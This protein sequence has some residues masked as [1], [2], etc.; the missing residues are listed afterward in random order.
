MVNTHIRKLVAAGKVL[1]C[2][3]QSWLRHIQIG[4]NCE[5]ALQRTVEAISSCEKEL[6]ALAICE[7]SQ[8]AVFRQA[9]G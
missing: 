5:E 8:T 1:I 9:F 6:A 3:T 2:D 4:R 7:Y